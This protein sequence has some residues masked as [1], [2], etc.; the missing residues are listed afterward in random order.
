MITQNKTIV[1]ITGILEKLFEEHFEKKAENVEAL[2]VSGSDRRYYRISSG[3]ISAIATYNT[4]IAENNTY[5]YFTELF[6]RHQINVPEVYK[7]SKVCKVCKVV[8][9]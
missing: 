2:A 6:R 7:V 8:Y 3:N 1:Q 5:F 4:N 9:V